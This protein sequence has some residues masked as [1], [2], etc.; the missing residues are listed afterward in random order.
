MRQLEKYK[1]TKMFFWIPPFFNDYLNFKKLIS[2]QNIHTI[3]FDGSRLTTSPSSG[4]ERS[5]VCND[6]DSFQKW[7]WAWS[8]KWIT[9]KK[10]DTKLILVFVKK[11]YIRA[12]DQ[13]EFLRIMVKID[14][15]AL[16]NGISHDA[17]ISLK[18]CIRFFCLRYFLFS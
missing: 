10:S 14:N 18:S 1:T 17:K 8:Q 5:P 15:S 4:Q 6:L 12:H 2:D 13:G 7:K 9:F 11:L 3:C 16:F